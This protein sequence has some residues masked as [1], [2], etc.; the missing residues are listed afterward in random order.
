MFILTESSTEQLG[1]RE[2]HLL[3]VALFQWKISHES[4]MSSCDFSPD[5]KYVVAGLD[6]DHG[7]CITDARNAMTVSYLKGELA[8]APCSVLSVMVTAACY[9]TD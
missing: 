4:F 7:I 1:Q 9:L 8:W 3:I 5:G 6:V 2:S